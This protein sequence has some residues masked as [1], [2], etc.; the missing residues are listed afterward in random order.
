M[1]EK[2]TCHAIENAPDPTPL[3]QTEPL[4]V[5]PLFFH[6][7]NLSDITL[8]SCYSESSNNPLGEVPTEAEVH[9]ELEGQA[10]MAKK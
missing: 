7:P 2:S 1:S 10:R 6:S 3:S 4:N 8:A 9:E 5:P